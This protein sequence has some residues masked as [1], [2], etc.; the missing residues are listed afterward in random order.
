MLNSLTSGESILEQEPTTYA[1]KK[2]REYDFKTPKKLSKEQLK[3]I[4]GIHE[5]FARQLSS[6]LSGI[7]R[8][9]SEVNILSI[10]EQHY[11]EYNNALPDTVLIGVIEFS[12]NEGLILVDFSNSITYNLIERILGGG[13]RESSIIPDREFSEIEITLM[14]RILKQIT[15]F[16]KEAWL[17]LVD[18]DV[19]LK[20][21]ETNARL[22][23][24]ISMDEI[25]V[26]V[27]MDVSIGNIKGTI[28]LCIPCISIEP[29]IDKM[30]QHKYIS[31]RTLDSSQEEIIKDSLT[32]NIKAAP[33]QVSAIFG[34]TVLTL[35]EILNLQIGDVIK[36]D[37]DVGTNI[38]IN[39]NNEDTWF[40]GVP[41]TKKNR[42]AVKIN[43]V[44]QKKGPLYNG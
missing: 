38:K 4:S 24:S 6:Y 8:T 32:T 14:E 30:N 23:Q 19:S 1:N 27:I 10:E 35:K 17:S 28:N 9:Y 22:I 37:H 12:S 43:K 25:V 13:S 20:Q 33:L 34:E 44:I 29:L 7:L 39:I 2:I 36:F 40:L 11:Y 5:N 42:K 21:I 41:G 31:K 3:V 15:V 18:G 26:I 16:M